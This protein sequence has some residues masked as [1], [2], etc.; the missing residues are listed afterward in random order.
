VVV[1]QRDTQL[2]LGESEARFQSFMRELP[3]G[4]F[5]QNSAGRYQFISLGMREL[6]GLG[7]QDQIGRPV[8]ESLPSEEAQAVQASDEEML[9]TMTAASFD[10]ASWKPKQTET[11]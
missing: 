10:G 8:A 3:G 7:A 11:D 4:A 1:E 2:S 5:I 6:L 9:A